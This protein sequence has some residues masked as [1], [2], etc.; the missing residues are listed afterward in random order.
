M[1][2]RILILVLVLLY[3]NIVSA[4]SAK[5]PE[6]GSVKRSVVHFRVESLKDDG[7]HNYYI[8]LLNM[9]LELTSDEYGPYELNPV[10]N[11]TF[12]RAKQ[13]ARTN[14]MD[15]FL[16]ETSYSKKV[17][18]DFEF[19]PLPIDLGI[20][21]Y[22]VCFARR[23]LLPSL[24]KVGSMAELKRYSIGQGRDWLDVGVL[25]AN[26]FKVVEL[27]NYL[28]LFPSVARGRFDLFCR[29]VHEILPEWRMHKNI[30]NL[31]VEESFALYYPFPRFFWTNAK[32]KALIQRLS[33]GLKMALE[34]GA[35]LDLS[36]RHHKESIE[37]S[38]LSSRKL[39]K[40]HNPQ[41]DG[42]NLEIEKYFYD[43]YQLYE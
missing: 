25:Q 18:S 3:S 16:F 38:K 24:A 14:A 23:E 35:V 34:D 8:D 13:I 15:N 7:L 5:D 29:S 21:S 11:T 6:I 17:H 4:A 1:Y 42:L 9:V 12:A 37:F 43:P 33:K 32:N 30:E 39:F 27:N 41:L 36:L 31:V 20:L 10:F 26:G 19:V 22:R 40:L 28:T 2:I